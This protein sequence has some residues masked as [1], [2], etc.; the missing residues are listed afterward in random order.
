MDKIAHSH[1]KGF[2]HRPKI[3]HI[4]HAFTAIDTA[5]PEMFSNM[6][7]SQRKRCAP[8]WLKQKPYLKIRFTQDGVTTKVTESW[9]IKLRQ[10]S[11]ELSG[12]LANYS[13]RVGQVVWCYWKTANE[14]EKA[15]FEA[16]ITEVWDN[17]AEVSEISSTEVDEISSDEFVEN[18]DIEGEGEILHFL[19]VSSALK[20]V[21]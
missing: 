2:T 1:V 15:Y 20:N 14:K 21:P 18:N 16:H 9:R 17:T 11:Q 5:T 7:R 19:W 10:Y 12:S 4:T 3:S 13:F 8:S 6:Q